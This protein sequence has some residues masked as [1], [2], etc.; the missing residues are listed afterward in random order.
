MATRDGS[1]PRLPRVAEPGVEGEPRLPT[2]RELTEASRFTY[3]ALCG[4]SLSQLFP[5]PEQRSFCT[6]FVA[7]LV[8]WL[9][10][11]EAVLP[12]MTA[13]ASGLGG[14]GADVFAEVL[15][16]DPILKDDPL[17]ITQDL[18]SFSLKDGCYDARARVLICHM[19]SLLR[20]PLEELDLLEETFLES[21]KESKE[22][23][24][25]SAEASRKKKENRRK[26]KRYLLIGLATVGGGTVIGVTGGLAA[27]LVAAGAATIIGSAGAAALGSAAGIAIM[28]SLFG[29]AGAGLTGYKMKKRVGAI[30]EFTFLPLTE[31]RQLHITIAITG[32]LA[33]GKYRT[34]SAPWAALARSREQY[35]LAWEAKYLMELGNALETILSGLANMVAQE[36]LKY[37]VLSGIVAA[38]TWPASLLS[39]ANVIDNPWGVCLH[40]SAEVGKHLAHILLSRQQGRRPVT[41]I[42]F[43]LGARVIYFCLQ[44]MAQ[45][46]DCQGIIEDVVLLG[47]P[48]D[49]EAKHW[50][51]FRKVVSGRIINGYCRADWLLSFV[52][53]TSSV[54]LHVAGLQPVVLQ[55]R[56]VENVDLSSVVSGHLDYARQMDVILK[57]VGIRTKPSWDEKGLLLAP[58]S[59]PQEESRQA[60]ATSSLDQTTNQ[61]EH[62]ETPGDIPKAA[63]PP[64]LRQ[65]QVPAGLDQSEG[66]SLPAATRPAESPPLCS[67]GLGAN[68]L[69]CPACAHETQGP[70]PGLD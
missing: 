9:D 5:E 48:V 23:D 12:T 64:D 26:W 51:P 31:G 37:T 2:G 62:P 68:P 58:G 28:T 57:A 56:R 69:G 65:A 6:D 63:I 66:A 19:A 7:G 40:R 4:I 35:C 13:F 67:H 59:L 1:G 54:R 36:A 18:L 50:E 61:D 8:K 11:S 41:L 44:E 21:L 70:C 38:L 42:G 55:D 29:A 47:A 39:V 16:K 20:A 17:V 24:S 53:R 46:K 10:L 43:S 52:Y 3:A 14:E 60:T 45:E 22:E 32:W 33:S 15:L 25:E 30:E 27:P 34:F 49:G